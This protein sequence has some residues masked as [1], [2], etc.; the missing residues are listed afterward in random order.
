MSESH[1][2]QER[3]ERKEGGDQ[4]N[5]S[6]LRRVRGFIDPNPIR[7]LARREVA[8]ALEEHLLGPEWHRQSQYLAT[9]FAKELN[10]T[11]EQYIASLPKFGPRPESWKKRSGIPVIVETRVPLERMLELAGIKVDSFNVNSII[12]WKKGKFRTPKS[13]YTT[14][15]N[16]GEVDLNTSVNHV[17]KSLKPDER[18]ATIYD[19]IALCIRDR[20]LNVRERSRLLISN[21]P[22]S[23]IDFGF[24]PRL[25]RMSVDTWVYRHLDDDDGSNSG[26]VLVAGRKIKITN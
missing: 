24:A 8:K 15:L 22:G 4:G 23:Q 25:A 26:C 21:L 11:Q 19:G 10:L 16:D 9:L 12:D 6:F 17:R 2:E 14:W 13:P 1:F 18:G 3:T 7:A 5:S 20:N